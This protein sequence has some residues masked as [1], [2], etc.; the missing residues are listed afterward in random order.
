MPKPGRNRCT[1]RF[2]SKFTYILWPYSIQFF[3]SAYIVKPIKRP[4]KFVVS[5]Q[6]VFHNRENKHD[7]VKTVT[8]KLQNLYV[9]QTFPD[10]LSRFH[11]IVIDVFKFQVS[12]IACTPQGTEWTWITTDRFWADCRFYWRNHVSDIASD[13]RWCVVKVHG[14]DSVMPDQLRSVD[15]HASIMVRITSAMFVEVASWWTSKFKSKLVT[16][17][18]ASGRICVVDQTV[19][20][21]HE[22]ME[23]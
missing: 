10:A 3:C 5:R 12:K 20:P 9:S 4:F 11:C 18:P 15:V 23:D 22:H 13:G 14:C 19:E 21:Q 7:F 2:A 8:G 16:D 6:V 1:A 17:A